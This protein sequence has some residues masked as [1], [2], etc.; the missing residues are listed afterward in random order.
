MVAIIPLKSQSQGGVGQVREFGAPRACSLSKVV[1]RAM[2][3]RQREEPSGSFSSGHPWH[4][5]T[6]S[7][8]GCGAR[9]AKGNY[10]SPATQ[11][12]ARGLTPPGPLP[13]MSPPVLRARAGHHLA[14]RRMGATPW[15]R[16]APRG[17][18]FNCSLNPRTRACVKCVAAECFSSSC[19]FGALA[20]AP[21]WRT[22]W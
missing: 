1:P 3:C 12:S 10:A 11:G 14:P 8:W 13:L 16:R 22:C 18:F 15:C 7:R 19:L 2:P 20:V 6:V 21:W 4:P 5:G 17:S 9:G